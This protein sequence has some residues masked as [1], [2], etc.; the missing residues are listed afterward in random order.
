MSWHLVDTDKTYVQYKNLKETPTDKRDIGQVPYEHIGTSVGTN[1][2]TNVGT[3]EN[4]KS[5]NFC[6]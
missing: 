4:V 6:T 1:H 5:I 3:N 2:G